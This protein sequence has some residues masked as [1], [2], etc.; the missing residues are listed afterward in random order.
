MDWS[1]SKVIRIETGVVS[2]S[3]N[4]LRELL[5]LYRID[6]PAQVAELVELARI[7]RRKPWWT[8]YRDVVPPAVPLLYRPR[9]RVQ[10]A[11]DVLSVQHARLFQTEEFAR[12][13]QDAI[14]PPILST[15]KRNGRAHAAG[16]RPARSSSG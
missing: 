11:T 6:D 15:R 14:V 1:L 7:G 13:V 16:G 10:R 5:R 3:T 8:R 2:I 4:D 12:A 9:R